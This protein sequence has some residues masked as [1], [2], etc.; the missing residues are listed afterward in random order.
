MEGRARMQA[1]VWGKT[2]RNSGPAAGDI[3]GRNGSLSS[4]QL[5]PWG[6][7]PPDRDDSVHLDSIYSNFQPSLDHIDSET[8]V[9]DT[10][11]KCPP[12]SALRPRVLSCHGGL[13]RKAKSCLR[14]ASPGDLAKK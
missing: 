9:R 2:K 4:N 7:F 12:P 10:Q 5:L 14:F 3:R 6:S 11:V 8:Q 1:K 13:F